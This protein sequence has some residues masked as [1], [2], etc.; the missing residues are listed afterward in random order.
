MSGH[1]ESSLESWKGTFKRGGTRGE[2]IREK[3]RGNKEETK[4]RKGMLLRK[5]FQR[6]G[7]GKK[8][9]RPLRSKKR[10]QNTEAGRKVRRI[11]QKKRKPC[12]TPK[13]RRV[14]C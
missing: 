14:R 12:A 3:R 2:G 10:K 13:K 7:G 6:G 9:C 5:L 11:L 8:N 1:G 4:H